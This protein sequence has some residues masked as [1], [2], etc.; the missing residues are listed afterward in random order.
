M[1]LKMT[2][3]MPVSKARW[4]Q[5]NKRLPPYG[6]IGSRVVLVVLVLH[7]LTMD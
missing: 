3:S 4:V 2:L 5:G 1:T 6:T 7:E